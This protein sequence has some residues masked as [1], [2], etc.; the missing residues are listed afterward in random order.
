M[1]NAGAL[2][3]WRNAADTATLSAEAGTSIQPE[4]PLSNLQVRGLA[5]GFRTA[6]AEAAGIR[7]YR[8]AAP[9]GID[10]PFRCD[11]NAVVLAATPH[12]RGLVVGGEFTAIGGVGRQRL[13]LVQHDGT[14]DLFYAGSA[15]GGAV[16]ALATNDDGA[17]IVGGKF[18]QIGATVRNKLARITAAGILDEVFNPGCNGTV[19]CLAIQDDGKILVGGSYTSIGGSSAINLARLNAD[20]TFDNTFNASTNLPVRDI[21]IQEDGKIIAV[22]SFT[23]VNGAAAGRI[24]RLNANGTIDATFTANCDLEVIAVAVQSSGKIVISGLF[25]DVNGTSN[26]TFARLLPGGALDSGF[27]GVMF[28][29]PAYRIKV[30]P[31][32]KLLLVGGFTGLGTVSRRAAGRVFADGSVDLGFNPGLNTAGGAVACDAVVV[33]GQSTLVGDFDIAGSYQRQNLVRLNESAAV[34]VGV[35][36]LL[37]LAPG[38][39]GDIA[40]QYRESDAAA[41]ATVAEWS[42]SLQYHGTRLPQL[43]AVPAVPAYTHG[44]YRIE[45]TA[46]V[47]QAFG[48]ARL[49]IGESVDFNEGIDASWRMG[50]RDSGGLDASAGGQHYEAEG[51]RTRLLHVSLSAQNTAKAWGMADADA[52]VG[53]DAS[54][55]D[56]QMEAGTT[57]EVIVIP[58]TSTEA[59]IK[60]TAV[61]GH[62]DSPW[63]IEHQ[64]GPNWRAAFT[65]EQER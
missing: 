34:R 25:D 42:A 51:V 60:R 17:V 50:F 21:A 32:D 7:I 33:A 52:D 14:V 38:L 4:W 62:I 43:F 45:Y 5:N 16:T 28:G 58:R 26:P 23:T 19:N 18:T 6:A 20:G 49:W 24:V 55:H 39:T 29:G 63:E 46:G 41:W 59:W 13:A 15:I 30:L 9:G 2:V 61:Y 64:S 53:Q 40:V 8:D 10:I 54:L 44:Q 1:S 35:I 65:V 36:G 31:N 22:G 48:F 27:V 56:L 11:A 12:L 47:A 3:S 37:G 57:A